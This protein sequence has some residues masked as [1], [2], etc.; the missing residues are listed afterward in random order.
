MSKKLSIQKI[1]LCAL[2][3]ALISVGA[4][5]KIPVPMVPF[6]LQTMFVTFAGLLLG[7][8]TGGLS[9]LLYM[10]LGLIGVPVF[11]GGG[12]FNYVL[13]PTFGYIIGFCISAY[14]IG[15]MT[16]KDSDVAS[17]KQMFVAMLV[18]LGITYLIG[19]IYFYII[20]N[21]VSGTNMSAAKILT[22]GFLMTIP[23]D[24][25]TCSLACVVSKRILP[26]ISKYNH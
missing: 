14:I 7:G 19:L 20:A 16:H 2:F 9:A 17:L 3:T 5:I 11:T 18:G 23:G 26:H 12:G 25:V 8:K 4:F 10:V 15:K 21:F 22:V 24:L 6:T 13:K 1:S